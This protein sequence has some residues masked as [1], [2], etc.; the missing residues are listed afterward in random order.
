MHWTP[1]LITVAI[2][3]VFILLKKSGEISTAAA[4]AHLKNGAL[5][6]D[7]RS[8]GEFNSSHLPEA[9]NIPLDEIEITLPRRVM[10]KNQVL[11]LHCLSG[12]RSGIAKSKFK[13]LGYV[14]VFNLG[15]LG[16]ARKISN[17]AKRN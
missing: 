3:T 11:L 5:I 14:N 9:I 12:T 1:V 4:H 6:I 17:K 10:D 15:S 13:R 16:R 8:S 2:V 7:V